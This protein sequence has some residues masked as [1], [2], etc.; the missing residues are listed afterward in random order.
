MRVTNLGLELRLGQLER[1]Y[2]SARE[3]LREHRHQGTNDA[4]V[5]HEG[6]AQF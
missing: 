3:R 6:F 1:A 2:A 5:D 4:L